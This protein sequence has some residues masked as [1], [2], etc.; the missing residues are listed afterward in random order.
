MPC[1]SPAGFS[2]W[3]RS[4]RAELAVSPRV[5]LKPRSCSESDGPGVRGRGLLALCREINSHE[6]QRRR[7]YHAGTGSLDDEE[8]PRE[9]RGSARLGLDGHVHCRPDCESLR[10]VAGRHSANVPT[11]RPCRRRSDESIILRAGGPLHL[12]RDSNRLATPRGSRGFA[13]LRSGG[14]SVEEPVASL[15]PSPP[16]GNRSRGAGSDGWAT[17]GSLAEVGSAVGSS[18]ESPESWDPAAALA[19][20][21]T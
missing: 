14:E 21:G 20:S 11:R 7:G 6:G 1:F 13:F 12:A 17:V 2:E 15:A 18:P 16:R 8:P 5:A 19:F 9:G 3:D 10:D 4:L